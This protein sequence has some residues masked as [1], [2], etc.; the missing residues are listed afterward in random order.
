MNE[1]RQTSSIKNVHLKN[2]IIFHD[3]HVKLKLWKFKKQDWKC[4]V[5]ENI[6]TCTPTMEGIGNSRGVGG[7]GQRPRKFQR[8]GGV[9]SEFMFPDGQVRCHA[10]LFQNRFL[11]TLKIFYIEKVA[12]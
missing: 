5:P 10:N 2:R 9:V 12:A 8:G 7:G 3:A 6:H 1:N 11:P 4:V